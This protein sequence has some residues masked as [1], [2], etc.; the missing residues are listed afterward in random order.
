MNPERPFWTTRRVV[1]YLA[2][3]ALLLGVALVVC[4]V[5]ASLRVATGTQQIACGTVVAPEAGRL[6]IQARHIAA[7]RDGRALAAVAGGVPIPVDLFAQA[8]VF[9]KADACER[10]VNARAALAVLLLLAG[11]LVAMP[12][13]LRRPA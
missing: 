5:Q 12:L 11:F 1:T 7:D 13:L 4:P 2:T 3:A 8:D 10:A 6:R 9:A